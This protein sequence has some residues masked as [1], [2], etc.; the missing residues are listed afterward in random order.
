MHF[1]F[2]KSWVRWGQARRNSSN[3]KKKAFQEKKKSDQ[4][5]TALCKLQL[6]SGEHKDDTMM[7]LTV[8]GA[9]IPPAAASHPCLVGEDTWGKGRLGQ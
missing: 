7:D 6:S 8:E 5:F 3:L 2:S 9:L 4:I 1:S